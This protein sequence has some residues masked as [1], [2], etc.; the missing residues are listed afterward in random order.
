[1]QNRPNARLSRS[2]YAC[3]ML[4]NMLVFKR[5]HFRLGKAVTLHAKGFCEDGF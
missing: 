3:S 4:R 2:R 5:S 1:M